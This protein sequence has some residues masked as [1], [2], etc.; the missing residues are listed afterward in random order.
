MFHKSNFNRAITCF[1]IILMVLA[2]A[3]I[4]HAQR[5]RR[6]RSTTQ[7]V[8]IDFNDFHGYTGTVAYLKDV[9]RAYPNITKLLEIGK[10]NMGRE[11]YVLVISNMAIGT[12]IDAHVELR[13][14]RKENVKNVTPMKPYQGKPAQ[15][16]DGGMHGNE[17]T[18]TEVCL[19]IIDKLI[20]GYDSDDQI[21]R[22]IDYN[23]F[24]FC[25]TV[26]PDG[27]FNS[28]ERDIPQ[29]QNSQL[30]DN[31]GDGRINEDGPD[32]LNRDGHITQFRYRDP[33][34]Q[35]I[36]DDVDP[37][38]MV[39]LGRDETTRKVRYSV[40]KEDI[41]NDRDGRRGEDGEAGIDVN[42]NF[43]EGWMREDGL[44]GGTGLYPSSSPEAHALCEFFTNHTNVLMIQNFHTS[45]GFTYRP[46][47]TA[48]DNSM[49]PKDVAVYD[50]IMGKKYLELNGLE[51]PPAWLETGSLDK[52]KEQLRQTSSNQITI[53]RG[54]EMPTGWIN[55]YN[56]NQDRRYGY[57][58]VIDWQ[59][60]Q[61]GAFSTC[62]ELW[63]SRRDMKGI[64]KFTG[65]DANLK[66]ERALLEYQDQEFGGRFFIPWQ[67][68]RHP[69]LGAGEIGGWIP[70]YRGNNAF[71]GET[72]LGICETHWQF[73]LFR[74]SLLPQVKVTDA[75]AKLLYTT[76]NS[77]AAAT[78]QN[79]TVTINA[80]KAQGPIKIVEV[81]ATVENVGKLATHLENGAQLAGNR[82]DVV[83]LITDR[84]KVTFVEGGVFQQ[85]GV[86]E[87]TM[88]IPGFAAADNATQNGNTSQR[89]VRQRGQNQFMTQRR[90]SGQRTQAA[91]R[92]MAETG[93][94]HQVRWL[95]A[96]EGDA[97]LKIV[98]TSQK[99]G[100]DVKELT[101][102]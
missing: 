101:I 33:Q 96:I 31:D 15:W 69:E 25:P 48:S 85:I 43:P 13:N 39:R 8:A 87:G 46:M 22:L 17:F 76:D 12:T 80:Q 44:P 49:G 55:G 90:P 102:K 92:Q 3:D 10:S 52:Y 67:T 58:M 14:Q 29:R 45:G 1:V 99:G 53:E 57:G 63:N 40:V 54:Y 75:Q 56:E 11:I 37:R 66:T 83:W 16:I 74:A 81:T 65:D 6:A 73:E 91:F 60:A 97:P 70:K 23:T 2:L 50:R 68:Y 9:A 28:T 77:K 32:D 30:K 41:D 100:T 42:R 93:N 24:Y 18:G 4:T 86:L 98:A 36:I 26:N 95:I 47:G 72:L 94:A 35:Y 59:Y 21:T 62:T 20:T 78:Q 84:D 34:G 61:L 7:R 38:L 89:T 64:P 27:V 79:G 51:V 5:Q 88:E 82:R 19:Y 71:P